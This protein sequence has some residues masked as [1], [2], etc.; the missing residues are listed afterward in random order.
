MTD[1]PESSITH[2]L[3]ESL[4]G[5]LTDLHNLIISDDSHVELW[6][7]NASVGQSA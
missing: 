4:D 3:I 1:E 6:K 7:W 5:R 2:V